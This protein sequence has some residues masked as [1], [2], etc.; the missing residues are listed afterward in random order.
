MASLLLFAPHAHGS[1]S[2]DVRDWTKEEEKPSTG[3]LPPEFFSADAASVIARVIE[4]YGGHGGIAASES[5][6]AKG[7]MFDVADEKYYT[8]M[9]YLAPGGLLRT[10]MVVGGRTDMQVLNGWRS[11]HGIQGMARYKI[12]GLELEELRLKRTCMT[13]ALLLS[14]GSY[15]ASYLG[16]ASHGGRLVYALMIERKDKPVLGVDVDVK[17][18]LVL[19]VTARLEHEGETFPVEWRFGD[20]VSVNSTMLP[21]KAFHMRDGVLVE[22][23]EFFRFSPN[24]AMSDSLFQ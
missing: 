10:D 21:K 8:Y 9:Y 22:R 3:N 2:A 7:R 19:N 24:P 18:G 13:I 6:F 14:K 11:F 12:K 5:M 4:A 1:G 15:G 17:T 20:Y 23:F 16:S